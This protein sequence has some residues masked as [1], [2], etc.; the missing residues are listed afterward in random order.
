MGI[1]LA[2]GVFQGGFVG[3]PKWFRRYVRGILRAP[4]GRRR[5]DGNWQRRH[6]GLGPGLVDEDQTLRRDLVLIF[7]PLR[8]PSR[9]VGTVAFASHHG[10]FKLSFSACTK[11]PTVL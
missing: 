9:D 7:G 2:P 6:V 1:T 8:P 11:L 3:S 10:F 5:F 4:R